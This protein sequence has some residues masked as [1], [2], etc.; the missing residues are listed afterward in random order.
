VLADEVYDS[1][2]E[3]GVCS[4]GALGSDTG[5]RGRQDDWF[6]R[7]YARAFDADLREGR[8]SAPACLP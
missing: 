1:I 7:R 2:Y 6:L 3:A 5:V 8:A 4:D